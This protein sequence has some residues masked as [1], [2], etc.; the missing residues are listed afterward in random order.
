MCEFHRFSELPYPRTSR[1]SDDLIYQALI[2]M[3]ATFS[4]GRGGDDLC[5]DG[6]IE[7]HPG[8]VEEKQQQQRNLDRQMFRSEFSVTD[9]LSAHDAN[10]ALVCVT[11]ETNLKPQMWAGGSTGVGVAFLADPKTNKQLLRDV[12]Q[13]FT[14]L[15]IADQFTPLSMCEVSRP[16][17]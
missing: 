11:C 12:Q 1:F 9:D 2:P 8:P 16:A 13:C 3:R 15:S 4:R 6:T 14:V 10:R 7:R 17:S 5:I